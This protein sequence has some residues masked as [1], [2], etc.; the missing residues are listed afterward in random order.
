MLAVVHRKY[1]QHATAM[2]D[3]TIRAKHAG[4][5]EGLDHI[6]GTGDTLDLMEWAAEWAKIPR[7]CC[8]QAT[9]WDDTT[10]LNEKLY[11]LL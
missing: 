10:F 2:F 7:T 11:I 1:W 9:E 3:T 5:T 8:L 6:A 4:L